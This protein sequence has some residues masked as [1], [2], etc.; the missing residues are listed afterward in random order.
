MSFVLPHIPYTCTVPEPALLPLRRELERRIC[1]NA[2]GLALQC[3]FHKTFRL[4]AHCLY[5]PSQ[6]TA[7]DLSP[8]RRACV[9]LPP[10]CLDQSYSCWSIHSSDSQLPETVQAVVMRAGIVV[11]VTVGDRRRLAAIVGNRNAPQKH[12]LAWRNHPCNRGRLRHG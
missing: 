1:F 6:T 3:F 9:E 5:S 4:L 2:D 12:V 7:T 11:N 8:H 10:F